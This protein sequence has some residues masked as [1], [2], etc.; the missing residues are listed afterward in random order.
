MS[1]I[2]R[3][4]FLSVA[5]CAGVTGTLANT[6]VFS[7]T[8]VAEKSS[9]KVDFN[10]AIESTFSLDG[11]TVRIYSPS[12]S[13]PVRILQISDSHLFLD[14]ER[15][16]DYLGNSDR[17]SH[18]YNVTRHYKNGKET[19]PIVAFKEIADSI[20]QKNIDAIVLTGDILSFPSAAGVD[21]IKECLTPLNIPYYYIAG[22]HDWHFEGLPGTSRDL[23]D[24]WIEKRLKSLYPAGS[25]PLAY[26]AKVKG[27]K[28]LMIDDSIYEILPKQVEFLEKE[29]KPNEP[30]LIF[31]HIPLYAPGRS[32]GYGVGHPEWNASTDNNYE[33]ERR[34][35][36]PKEGHTKTTFLFRNE[37]LRASNILGVFT[38]HV[39]V[40]TLD[41]CDGKSLH[42]A[43][44]AID[45]ST[46]TIEIQ[47][48]P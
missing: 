26:S 12:I 23:R 45:A 19:N 18:A 1:K 30:T 28:I 14:D 29:L 36:W 31:M 7:V 17:M 32:V 3:R 25:D 38:G 20:P 16:K 27:L 33:I 15:G 22:N 8:D 9:S 42:T 48:M 39:H 40:Q 2:T 13:E 5:S 37:I 10:N 11:Q 4:R 34:P 24:E 35:R 43:P 6:S 46:I 44:A 47:P 41:V 21:Y